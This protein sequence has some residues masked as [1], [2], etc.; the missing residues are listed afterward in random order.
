MK[1]RQQKIFNKPETCP[2]KN[3]TASDGHVGGQ[4]FLW[5]TENN[6][7]EPENRQENGLL[8]SILSPANLNAAYKRVKGNKGAAG[9][10]KM[11]VGSLKDYL[12]SHKDTLIE[13]ILEGQYRPNPTRRVLI[14]K[15]NG[16]SVSWVSLQW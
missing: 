3:R 5:I 6:L 2:Q 11:E 8:E 4:T 15:G 9:V 7:T 14:P 10:D 12:V 1:D 13:S 16:N